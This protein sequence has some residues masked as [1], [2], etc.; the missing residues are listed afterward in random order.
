VGGRL[1]CAG[2][3]AFCAF[4]SP[5]SADETVEYTYDVHGRLIKV[6]RCGADNN[7]AATA[8]NIDTD[9]TYDDADNRTNETTTVPPG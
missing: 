7:C 9:Y 2:A 8:D 1:F 4:A 5:A 3:L 6:K